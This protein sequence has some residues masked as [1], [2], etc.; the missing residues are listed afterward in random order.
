MAQVF[1]SVGTNIDRQANLS[2]GLNALVKHFG[3]L[4]L[5]SLF[6]SE[7][8]GFDGSPFFNMVVGFDT[9]L[10]IEALSQLLREIEF[11]HGREIDAKKFSPRTLDLDILL[12]DDLICQAPV[13]LPREEI[14]YN[15]FVLWPLAEVAPDVIHPILNQSFRQLW[16][17]YDKSQQ[18]LS[19]VPLD[20][21]FELGS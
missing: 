13:Q 19:K 6:E 4:R 18:Q 2:K 8:V 11:A 17:S 14:T 15:A 21:S 5:S 9:Q 10:S 12:F 16:Q 3:Q 20:W 7:A 1:V